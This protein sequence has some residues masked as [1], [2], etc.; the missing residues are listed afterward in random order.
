MIVFWLGQKPEHKLSLFLKQAQCHKP[1]LLVF[2]F[3]D[4]TN[5]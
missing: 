2:M 5:G 1:D 3:V 4:I